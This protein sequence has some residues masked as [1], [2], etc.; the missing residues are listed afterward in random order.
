[1]SVNGVFRGGAFYWQRGSERVRVVYR[2]G[3]YRQTLSDFDLGFRSVGVNGVCRG[4]AYDKQEGKA[5][6]G[7]SGMRGNWW[8]RT[9]VYGVIGFLCYEW[10]NKTSV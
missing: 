9:L 7:R 1:M 8:P 4:L 6:R 10:C 5:I 2:L 3:A